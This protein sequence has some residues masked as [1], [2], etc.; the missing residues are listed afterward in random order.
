MFRTKH[1]SSWI[2]V[3]VIL[4]SLLSGCGV[5]RMLLPGGDD[6]SDN[7]A[8]ITERTVGYYIDEATNLLLAEGTLT[9]SQVT[10]SRVEARSY[11][12]SANLLSYDLDT[13]AEVAVEGAVASIGIMGFSDDTSTMAALDAVVSA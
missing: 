8:I 2:V 7:P 10:T 5:L 9:G 1:R 12:G 6:S 11:V 13:Y 4:A 3:L